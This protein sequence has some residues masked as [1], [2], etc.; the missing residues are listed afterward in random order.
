MEKQPKKSIDINLSKLF[1]DLFKQYNFAIFVI[2]IFGG[3]IYAVLDF[4]ETLTKP[5]NE[6]STSINSTNAQTDYTTIFDQKTIDN[7]NKLNTPTNNTT[8]QPLPSGRV[9]PFSE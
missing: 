3:L 6:T 7:L 8:D 4:T 1:S 2:I 9:N 5:F